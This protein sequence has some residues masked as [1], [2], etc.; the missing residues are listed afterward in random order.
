MIDELTKERELIILYEHL[1]N[2]LRE[3][4]DEKIIVL[5]E[6]SELFKSMD[7]IQQRLDQLYKENVHGEIT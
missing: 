3:I 6:V 1:Y 4:A 2:E 5:D 7:T